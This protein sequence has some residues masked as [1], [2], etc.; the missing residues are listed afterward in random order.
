MLMAEPSRPEP[1]HRDFHQ[2]QGA[3]YR[4]VF[5]TRA[6]HQVENTVDTARLDGLEQG[7]A[8]IEHLDLDTVA[9]Q[10]RKYRAAA[11]ERDLAFGA[12]ATHQQTDVAEGGRDRLFSWPGSG[13]RR[14][15]PSETGVTQFVCDLLDAA[16][17]HQQ[18]QVTIL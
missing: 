15:L 9:L 4:A 11:V 18:Y 7:V 10:G 13:S 14:L 5:A 2:L 12:V 1:G 6:V 17:T 8:A 16:C 3:L